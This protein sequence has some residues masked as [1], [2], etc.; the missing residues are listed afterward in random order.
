MGG[1]QQGQQQGMGRP[2]S[3]PGTA[4]GQP[5]QQGFDGGQGQGGN[6][7]QFNMN[8]MNGFGGGPQ[9]QPKPTTPV[10]FNA[11]FNI[12]GNPQQQGQGPGGGG[13]M[14]TMNPQ[15][16]FHQGSPPPGSPN[17][18]S[19]YRG[20][21]RKVGNGMDSPR[22]GGM[23]MP[24]GMQRQISGDGGMGVMQGM[25]GYPPSG[26]QT[27]QQM[28]PQSVNGH[29]GIPPAAQNNGVGMGGMGGGMGGGAG[30]NNLPGGISIGGMSP[31]NMNVDL[32]MG[33]GA[34]QQPQQQPSR[35][36]SNPMAGFPS[37]Q[38][39][40][41]GQRQGQ[42]IP[43]KPMDMGM[44]M[45][46]PS[47]GGI[48]G[49][50]PF[51]NDL[52]SIGGRG[53][54]GLGMGMPVGNGLPLPSRIPS[55]APPPLAKTESSVPPVQPVLPPL[56]ANVQLN[57]NVT[58][59]SIIPLA[60]SDKVIPTLTSE[61]IEEIQ[62]WQARDKEYEPIHR[63]MRERMGEEVRAGPTGK[64]N[65]WEKDAQV[66]AGMMSRRPREPFDVKYPRP[67]KER[68]GRDR[69]K[70]GRREG[71]KLPRILKPEEADRP[72]QL[73][74]IRLE[75]D[76]EHHKMRD[77][78]VWN[79]NGKHIFNNFLHYTFNLCYRSCCYP[80]GLCSVRR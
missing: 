38:P 39:Q 33:R 65:W 9:H 68:D 7:Q 3:R 8:P 50:N 62:G 51:G 32:P 46:M 49:S 43:Q 37:Q 55:V 57:P 78:F 2:P 66:A 71:L 53:V 1:G 44:G 63:K 76:V 16:M 60:G 20:A 11:P 77:S 22:M 31:M 12:G 40:A 27:H 17:P 26:G 72:E 54:G 10:Q 4:G 80:R 35:T 52:G 14:N 74:P 6:S 61:E 42:P 15:A 70:V 25:N 28:R 73:V 67:K 59:V 30:V 58:R 23:G 79:L 64:A 18:N 69:R 56:P 34:P 75:F 13:G 21:K 47:A 5:Q 36:P 19:A 41:Q 48:G 29:I 24:P 45:K